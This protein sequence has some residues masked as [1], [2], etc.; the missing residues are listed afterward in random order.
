MKK[1]IRKILRYFNIE[2][3]N[4]K[5]INTNYKKDLNFELKSQNIFI[6]CF[7]KALKKKKIFF[8][9]I[10][11]EEAQNI[12]PLIYKKPP[13]LFNLKSIKDHKIKKNYII[14]SGYG[15]SG[16]SSVVDYLNEFQNIFLLQANDHISEFR[17][18]K[19]FGGLFDFSNYLNNHNNYWSNNGARR[20]FF[21]LAKVMNRKSKKNY[22]RFLSSNNEKEIIGYNYAE[23]TN[24]F[25]IKY[26]EEYL[27]KIF[28]YKREFNWYNDFINLS[29][30]ESLIRHCRIN[31]NLEEKNYFLFSELSKEDLLN[32]TKAFLNKMFTE[33]IEFKNFEKNWHIKKSFD[34][35]S[36][37]INQGIPAMF[38]DDYLKIYPDNSKLVVVDRDPRDIYVSNLEN[39]FWPEEVD[40]FCKIFKTE[41]ESFKKQ[42]NKNIFFIQF[43]EWIK[44]NEL[45]SKNL[46]NFL[47]I[48]SSNKSNL[49][50]YYNSFEFSKS[51]IKKWQRKE[52]IN[53]SD[54]FK[55][56]EEQLPDYCF[57]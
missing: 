11:P 31:L 40:I 1:I 53:K 45:I 21:N 3:F 16:S 34:N 7:N 57:N 51:R 46:L 29:F 36:L 23:I 32:E 8:L 27:N 25:F 12:Q 39:K 13:V 28:V 37:I 4:T 38:A 9:K 54:V 5:L 43:E 19:D 15:S 10:F 18:V 49:D 14:V 6:R 55:K 35:Y 2:I 42:K 22:F 44:N 41:R 56:I 30:L 50:N 52:F 33:I 20:N 48:D 26:V 24:N 47:N 17:L